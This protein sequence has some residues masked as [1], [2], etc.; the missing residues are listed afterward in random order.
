MF[1]QPLMIKSHILIYYDEFSVHTLSKMYVYVPTPCVSHH[2]DHLPCSS[3]LLSISLL[4]FVL[5]T[6][7]PVLCSLCFH[8]AVIK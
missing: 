6:C 7:K 3:G 5:L 4:S 8:A 2:S 1:E